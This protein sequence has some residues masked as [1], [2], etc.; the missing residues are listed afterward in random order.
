MSVYFMA[1]KVTKTRWTL[2]G[3]LLATCSGL[4]AS[5]RFLREF[6]HRE[7]DIFRDFCTI[8]RTLLINIAISTIIFN[9]SKYHNSTGSQRIKDSWAVCKYIIKAMITV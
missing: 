1:A 6:L 3:A 2:S 7:N 8:F 4:V 9:V 5:V